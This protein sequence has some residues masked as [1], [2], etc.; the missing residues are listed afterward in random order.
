MSAQNIFTFKIGGQA[1]QGIKLAGLV[2]SKVATRSGYFTF[3]HTEY[4]SLIRGGHNMMQISVSDEEVTAPFKKTDF[5]IAL[6][7]ETVDKYLN[8]LEAGAGILYDDKDSISNSGLKLFPIPLSKLAAD[9]NGQEILKNTVAIGA[10]LALAGG[11]LEIL[12]TLIEEEFSGKSQLIG[13]NQQAAQ[14]G[15]DYALEKYKNNLSRVLTPKEGLAKKIIINGNEAV[16]FGAIASNM[17]FSSIYPMSPIS[18]VIQVLASHQEK[19]GYIYR[20]PEDEIAAINMAI[21]AS[22]A[23]ARSLTATSGGGF[24]LMTEGLGLSAMT[25]TPLVVV[26]GMRSGP[27]TGLPTWS[28]QGDLLFVLNAHQSDFPK[29]I[30]AP[31]DAQETFYLTAKAFNLAAKYQL[32]VIILID[33]NICESDQSFLPFDGNLEIEEGK[34]VKT[35]QENFERFA[36]S[37]DGV[38]PRTLPGLGNFLIANSDEHNTLGYSSDEV[39]DRQEQM[40]KRMSKMETIIKTEDIAPVLRGPKKADLTIVSWGSNKGVI[41]QVIKQFDKVNF[42]QINWI[43]PFPSEQVKDILNN[44]SHLLD[45]ECNYSAQLAQLIRQRTGLEITDKLLKY[46]GRPFFVEE[47]IQKINSFLKK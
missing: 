38:S 20:Q 8:Q 47:V 16:A 46:D 6:N 35:K 24:C 33:K 2:L 39:K 26:E 23:G 17:Q 43:H 41:L 27:A 31:G 32:P 25:E 15:Y 29:I 12:K 10:T 28:E 30:L 40:Q 11:N 13:V 21:G 18:S 5:L 37:A 42:L 3:D 7:R 22:F 34:L 44:A 45:I 36:L 14:A 4:P 19:F 1:G 9:L